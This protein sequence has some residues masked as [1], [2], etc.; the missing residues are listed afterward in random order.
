MAPASDSPTSPSPGSHPVDAGNANADV[1]PTLRPVDSPPVSQETSEAPAVKWP[2]T[3]IELPPPA[4]ASLDNIRDARRPSIQIKP[5]AVM[6]GE[7]KKRPTSQTRRRL[8]SP[9]PP[10]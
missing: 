5:H 6:S 8:S 1:S 7:P 2:G 9:P 3:P 4:A 10:P